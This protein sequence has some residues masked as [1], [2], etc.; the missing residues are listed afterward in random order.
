MKKFLS[1]VL[2]LVMTMSLV[3][4]SAGA[5]DF[6]DNSKI[7][8]SEAVDVMS[9]VKV[10]D[11]YADGSFNPTATLT[12]G[13]AAKIICNMILGPT[14]A[15]ALVAD[16]APYKDV[17]ANHTF[18]G[19]IAYCQKTGIIS[20]YADGTF[21]PANTLT[22]YAFMKMLLGALGYKADVEGYTS[23]NWSINVAKQAINAGLKDG[24]KG[25]FNGVKAVNREEACLYAF[26]TLKA[27]MVEYDTTITIGGVT[28]AGA[29]KDIA[30]TAAKET[31]KSDD[32]MQ[33]AEKYFTKLVKSPD[34]DDFGRPATKWVNDKKEVGS[35]VDYTQMVAEYTAKVTGK[36]LYDLLGSTAIKNSDVNV[37]VDGETDASVLGSAYFTAGKLVKTNTTK[38]GATGNGVLT[39]VFQNTDEDEINIV[40][41]NT[42]LAKVD[43]DYSEKQDKAELTVYSIEDKNNSTNVEQ[44]AKAD[45]TESME[46]KGEDFG[47]IVEDMKEDDI[48]LVTVA[49][50]EIQTIAKPET[51]AN[52]EISSFKDGSYLTVSGTKYDFG[53][54]LK[55]NSKLIDYTGINSQINLK[56]TT[57]NVYLDSYGYVIGIDEVDSTTNYVFVT[58]YDSNFSN[59]T[60]KTADVGAIFTDGTMKVI[61]V[62]VKDSEDAAGNPFFKGTDKPAT[63]NTWC[64]YTVDK[65]GVYT[66]KEVATY[67]ANKVGQYSDTDYTTTIEK[68]HIT[69]K[70]KDSGALAYGN[71][72]SIYLVVDTDVIKSTVTGNPDA[73]IISE[74]DSV[75]TGI[76]NVNLVPKAA[77]TD[78]TYTNG[79][80]SGG[81][82]TLFDKNS[83]VIAAVVVGEN[84]SASK[85]YAYVTSDD[86]K[87]ESY[88][89]NADEYTWSRDVI[90]DGV[91]TTIE[92]KGD[93]LK[94]ISKAAMKQGEWYEVRYY[95][96]GT[97]KTTD[98]IDFTTNGDK[99]GDTVEGIATLVNLYDEVL[100]SD[101]GYATKLTCIGATLYTDTQVTK[102][103]PVAED[104]KV[105][106]GLKVDGD[107]FDTV[108]E[109][110]GVKGLEKAIRDLDANNDA[111][112]TPG[113]VEVNAIIENGVATTVILNDKTGTTTNTGSNTSNGSKN[114]KA[115]AWDNGWVNVYSD[116]AKTTHVNVEVDV[117]LYQL[118]DNGYVEVGTYTVPK[119]GYLDLNSKMS[120]GDTYK[121]VCGIY[122]DTYV[123]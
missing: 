64:T 88:D 47:A 98:L 76:K 41:I 3:T 4:V 66:L 43:A 24:L 85:N 105:F 51:V 6:T 34:N 39:Q 25:D 7:N 103:F 11:G 17:P 121:V 99:F 57:Y 8:Y 74:V 16:A 45:H 59:L 73:V 67:A 49:D 92:Y 112:F 115:I 52:T 21:K 30:N 56:D 46:V 72:D 82:Y 106:L 37:Y 20:G 77:S 109:Y 78:A 28:V 5:K 9:A 87:L 111:G 63:R 31:I 61:E 96:D 110:S 101:T 44:Y 71:N 93:S 19:Y 23:P 27:T 2:A 120:T 95:A 89:K 13:A 86:V 55:F 97:V 90:V 14:T 1:L 18:A 102:G 48:V 54:T 83:Y 122:S 33:F 118:R 79:G 62:K 60:A 65:N 69:L 38:V 50:G 123:K 36:D 116:A 35:Y 32:K 81:V 117:V 100:L 58:G 107:E 84:D 70:A 22:G 80:A 40:I 104:A 53:D 108:N 113:A 94:Q 91:L 42:Y 15:G 75:A 29:R 10:I 68:K 26:N 114:V 119:V 12:R